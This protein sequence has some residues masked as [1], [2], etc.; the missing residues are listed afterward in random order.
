MRTGTDF[1]VQH[2]ESKSS[3]EEISP[4]SA[5]PP[6]TARSVL[7]VDSHPALRLGIS[8]LLRRMGQLTAC[9]EAGD[10]AEA[11]HRFDRCRPELV[12]MDVSLADGDGI[13]LA[14]QMMLA[15]PGLA[16]LILSHHDE[17]LY[18]ARALA[19]GALGYLKK[20]E[21][22]KELAQALS[23]VAQHQRYLSRCFRS[24]V[25]LKSLLHSEGSTLGLLSPL[26]K[27]EADVFRCLGQGM[28]SQEIAGHLDL[29]IK[30]VDTHRANIKKKLN[31][32]DAAST[33]RLAEEWHAMESGSA[34]TQ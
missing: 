11:W 23:K 26:S 21:G 30:T 32:G 15:K 29:G 33:S 7:V 5:D 1:A 4:N 19:A 16:V 8:A 17:P 14:R 9:C 22:L 25:L 2:M 34:V 10:A 3:V 12:V 28:G 27:R 24:H 6:F 18:A 13:A 20:D 31:L